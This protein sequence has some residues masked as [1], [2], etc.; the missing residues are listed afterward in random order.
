MVKIIKKILFIFF[1]LLILSAAWFVY[2]FNYAKKGS[3]RTVVFEVKEGSSV[4][5][6]ARSL[7]ESD[8][9]KNRHIFLLGYRIFFPAQSLRAGEYSIDRPLSSREILTLLIEGRVILYP[10]TI[11]EGLTRLEI[12]DHIQTEY[13]VDKDSFLKASGNPGSIVSMDAKAPNLEG[14][15]FPETYH[16]PKNTSAR[17]MVDA[18]VDQFISVFDLEW[19]QRAKNLGFSIREI[20]IL[21]SLIEEET[22][23]PEERTLVSATFH[24]R[25]RIGMK[26]DCDPTIIYALKQDN[27]YTGRL[28]YRDL[29]LDSPYNTYIYPGLP[30]GPIC[31]PGRES[32]KAAL[33]PADED[34]LYFV[35]KND[36]SH[37]FSRTFREHQN[38]VNIYQKR[39]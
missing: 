8:L 12:A 29:K 32:L 27:A 37:Q 18:M 33:Y 5:S 38:A 9:I 16:F 7:E 21:A 1:I 24:N 30:P 34:Y 28:R 10:I 4:R 6:I 2:E 3:E 31:N 11:P 20:V 35:S 25:L 39:K 17:S 22:S 23:H 15:L 36:G 26:L 13:A 19:R 14:Y